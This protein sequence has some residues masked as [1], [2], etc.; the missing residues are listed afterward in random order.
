MLSI[1]S[2]FDDAWLIGV[3]SIPYHKNLFEAHAGILSGA[4]SLWLVLCRYDNSLDAGLIGVRSKTLE[5]FEDGGTHALLV[6]LS[7]WLILSTFV[8][9]FAS[10]FVREKLH[11][12]GCLLRAAIERRGVPRRLSPGRERG[13]EEVAPF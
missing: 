12:L 4:P 1:L 3:L 10:I 2:F 5:L 13:P 8:H 6:T 11:A 9:L 7:L